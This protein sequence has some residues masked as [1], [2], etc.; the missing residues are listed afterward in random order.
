MRPTNQLLPLYY[1]Y[2]NLKLSNIRE[3]PFSKLDHQTNFYLSSS[4]DHH[5]SR[6]NSKIASERKKNEKETRKK[7][8]KKQI[9]QAIK[10][11]NQHKKT[12]PFW[13]A[14]IERYDTWQSIPSFGGEWEQLDEGL[15]LL[16][17]TEGQT[18]LEESGTSFWFHDSKVDFILL[19]F[20]Q[21]QLQWGCHSLGAESL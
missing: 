2:C 5:T 12:W 7:E 18:Y 1:Y 4:N 13:Q 21:T 16:H 6:Y 15:L 3:S 10:R 19:L 8:R 17:L 14:I 20:C 11:F 9:F